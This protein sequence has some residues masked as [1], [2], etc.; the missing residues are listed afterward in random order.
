MLAERIE[1]ILADLADSNDQLLAL[2]DDLWLDIDHTDPDSIQVGS[3]RMI[4]VIDATKTFQTLCGDISTRL[5]EFLPV[6]EVAEPQVVA[7]KESPTVFNGF[8]TISLNDQWSYRK[9]FGFSF[10]GTPYRGKH[11][12]IDLYEAI[13]LAL[14]KL[15][16]ERFNTVP[17]RREIISTHGNPYFSRD[18]HRL[19]NRTEISEGI[20]METNLS[21]KLI[22]DNIRRLLRIFEVPES[23]LTIYTRH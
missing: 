20:Y 21:A 7:P 3:Q 10:Q 14:K 1:S 17:D 5:K 4:G 12:W 6:E 2:L 15:D 23:D 22:R 8:D 18:R 11:N 19:R 13:C 9:P 16:S